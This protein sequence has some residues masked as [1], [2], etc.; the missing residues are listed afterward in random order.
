M[1]ISI[2]QSVFLRNGNSREIGP[3]VLSRLRSLQITQ[4][5]RI[6]ILM[7]VQIGRTVHHHPRTEIIV[8]IIAVINLRIGKCEVF[9]HILLHNII[10]AQIV[11]HGFRQIIV[12]EFQT[13]MMTFRQR[14]LCPGNDGI[15]GNLT[16]SLH[17]IIKKIQRELISTAGIPLLQLVVV[18]HLSRCKILIGHCEIPAVQPSLL[19]KRR[20][21]LLRLFRSGHAPVNSG[22]LRGLNF[23]VLFLL[24]GK[25]SIIFF[26]LLCVL[27]SCLGIVFCRLLCFRNC[28]PGGN[29]LRFLRCSLGRNSC[30]AACQ[31]QKNQQNSRCYN[32]SFSCHSVSEFTML[33][34]SLVSRSV[35]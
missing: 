3:E 16:G 31:S 32:L 12:R 34:I 20:Y 14:R 21:Q 8:M 2:P 5:I 11:H 22:N 7:L 15:P 25:R 24:P 23:S 19:H 26:L 4:R 35:P 6:F 28:L 18:E 27:R 30:P 17:V 29:G 13:L 33:R 1:V 10:A 9:S